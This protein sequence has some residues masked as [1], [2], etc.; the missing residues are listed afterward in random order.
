[1]T[2]NHSSVDKIPK[3]KSS[4]VPTDENRDA[5]WSVNEDGREALSQAPASDVSQPFN[6]SQVSRSKK[7]PE[8][9]S[10]EFYRDNHDLRHSADE[11]ENSR[12]W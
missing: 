5:E 8:L 4:D 10:G 9:A 12:G 3:T 1:V 11:E 2:R 7:L 6:N